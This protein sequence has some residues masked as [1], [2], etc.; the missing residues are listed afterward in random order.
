LQYEVVAD[1]TKSP[2]QAWF[3]NKIPAT[4]LQNFA[5]SVTCWLEEFD[6]TTHNQ[7][8]SGVEQVITNAVRGQ[9]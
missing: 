9:G 3:S 1:C 7:I 5:Y 6:G 8:G 4:Y 2:S